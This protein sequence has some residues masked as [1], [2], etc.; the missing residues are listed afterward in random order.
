MKNLQSMG[1]NSCYELED[2]SSSLFPDAIFHK[3]IPIS[4]EPYQAHGSREVLG[5][6]IRA[7]LIVTHLLLWVARRQHAKGLW[8][9][10]KWTTNQMNCLGWRWPKHLILGHMHGSDTTCISTIHLMPSD[11]SRQVGN[12]Q[13]SIHTRMGSWSYPMAYKGHPWRIS[14]FS[15]WKCSKLKEKKDK[16]GCTSSIMPANRLFSLK[17]WDIFIETLTVHWPATLLSRCHELN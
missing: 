15:D 5:T 12:L 6:Q 16:E 14:F 9:R 17:C 11:T 7:L 13:Q 1:N 10:R 8:R 3:S 2:N 4:W